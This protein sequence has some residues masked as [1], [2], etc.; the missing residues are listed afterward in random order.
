MSRTIQRTLAAALTA[1]LAIGYSV[2][3]AE[4][5][6]AVDAAVVNVDF[7]TASVSAST[8]TNDAS[9][10]IAD[11]TLVGSPGQDATGMTFANSISAP[12]QYLTG[13]LGSTTS[14]SKI[15]IEM[16]AKFPDAGCS[17]QSSGS[18]VFGLGSGSSSYV[19][20]NIYRHSNFIGFNTFSSEVF[21]IVLPDNNAFHTY[22][23]VM[24]PDPTLGNLQEIWVDN[25]KQTL[26]FKTSP[27]SVGDCSGLGGTAESASLRVFKNT[28]YTN[29]D[30]M[31]MT[32]PLG[33]SSWETAGTLQSVSITT[34]S[35]PAPATPATPVLSTQPTSKYVGSGGAATLTVAATR[36]DSGT[37]KY[38][39][40][41]SADGNTWANEGTE[42]TSAELAVS[43]AQSIKQY[44]VLVK[45][46]LGA[47]ASAAVTSSV[48][49][50]RVSSSTLNSVSWSKSAMASGDSN[51]ISYNGS[52]PATTVT[53]YGCFAD[54]ENG[55]M[56]ARIAG[57]LSWSG[58]TYPYS[59]N[60]SAVKVKTRHFWFN[61]DSNGAALNSVPTD[62]SYADSS[63]A[64][65]T[66]TYEVYPATAIAWAPSSL[67][68]SASAGSLTPSSGATTNSTGAISYAVNSA[69]TT[70]CSVN[71]STGAVNFTA[72]GSC[73]VRA[74]VAG[75]A[76]YASAFIDKTFTITAALTYA[77]SAPMNASAT[78]SDSSATVTWNAPSSNGGAA[79][80]GYT[81]TASPGGA[82]CAA[83]AVVTTCAVSGLTNG[84]AYTFAVTA[85]NSAGTSTASISSSAVTPSAPVVP[86]AP[87]INNVAPIAPEPVAPV[88]PPVKV[89]SV[90]LVSGD[91]PGRSVVKVKLAEPQAA[92]LKSDLRVRIYD[93]AGQ[94][95]KEL[96]IPVSAS[97]ATLELEVDLPVGNFNVEAAAVNAAG[98][99]ESVAAAAT[100]VNRPL[101]KD[102][103]T[104]KAPSL[105][106]SIASKPILFAP[107]SAALSSAAK[108]SLIALVE[109]LK[110]SNSRIALTGFTARWT[111]G[112][113]V[114]VQLSA[115]RSLAVAEFLKTQG[116]TN[117]IYYAG[118]GSVAGTESKASARKVE[119]RVLR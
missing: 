9:S 87:V 20:Y 104:S 106:G 79:I 15:V 6:M 44:R 109:S 54:S 115:K 114:E 88:L 53:F 31:L 73:V 45:N 101:F 21:G 59:N 118:Y 70:G 39:W 110:N 32:H 27:S 93:F 64:N 25:V 80:T 30:F 41:S 99:S 96:M 55:V 42:T 75:V 1:A 67:T 13:N 43:N 105:S 29:G 116:L 12:S 19:N 46:Y 90:Q 48:A 98:V 78:G 26:G 49:Y 23:F 8:I 107:N 14:M 65:L 85:T 50:L 38:Q 103:P 18:M 3:L 63:S 89:S 58:G 35:D 95:I 40:Q 72:A 81:V 94:L 2:A 33:A 24:V 76:L 92:V 108:S 84:T 34:T 100:I 117:W 71:S 68:A 61:R 82:T 10:K 36:A 112:R 83:T 22:K 111:K 56:G 119:L 62:C 4:P 17:S 77:P 113:S 47:T 86:S 51:T 5:A 69:G 57:S 74:T 7:R 97:A 16:T 52:N 37:L 66:T 102:V 60:T 28:S 11:L 91:K